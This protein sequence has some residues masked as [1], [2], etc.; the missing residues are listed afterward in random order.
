MN[1]N[2]THLDYYDYGDYFGNV[3]H[4]LQ[5]HQSLSSVSVY[6]VILCIYSLLSNTFIALVVL[7]CQD[8][9]KHVIY[10]QIVNI[11]IANIINSA[12][13][14][15]LA[16]Y[17]D[18][19]T[20]WDLGTLLCRVYIFLDVLLPYI[21]ILILLFMNL[22][23]MFIVLC[24]IVHKNMPKLNLRI[25]P[26][27][28]L[29]C[30]WFLAVST[31]VPIWVLGFIDYGEHP[32]YC[33]YALNYEAS[34]LSPLV[35]YFIPASCIIVVITFVLIFNVRGSLEDTTYSTPSQST[36][37]TNTRQTST[38]S[39]HERKQIP[40]LTLC[41][42]DFFFIIMLFPFQL[43]TIL[44]TNCQNC[45]PPISAIIAFTWTA[46]T[47]SAV[48]PVTWLSDSNIRACVFNVIYRCLC[49]AR[50]QDSQRES[51]REHNDIPLLEL[52]TTTT[53][54][55]PDVSDSPIN[56]NGHTYTTIDT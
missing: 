56:K 12:I 8:L 6:A 16:I 28:I 23:R 17:T 20:F 10:L 35:V 15:P 26:F 27:I 50:E 30:P 24:R 37:Y 54:F 41:L 31:I 34:L 5:I 19:N 36:M 21:A 46:A 38:S 7:S 33:Y 32:G 42:A 9:R 44:M 11:C 3:S 25:M 52:S 29:L 45:H 53:V 48:L 13:V 40:L 4:I 47:Y 51:N 14:I 18:I 39:L 22:D 2:I 43:Y 55:V 1:D 49:C